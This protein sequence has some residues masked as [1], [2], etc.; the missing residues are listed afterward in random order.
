MFVAVNANHQTSLVPPWI[1]AAGQLW[2]YIFL[3]LKWSLSG[4]LS[5]AL[6]QNTFQ[7]LIV[8]LNFIFNC[9]VWN[10]ATNRPVIF[11]EG[12]AQYSFHGADVI[13]I[14]ALCSYNC[15]LGLIRN[16]KMCFSGMVEDTSRTRAVL[17][18]SSYVYDCD[19]LN[20]YRDFARFLPLTT[21]FTLP[22]NFQSMP[23]IF[24]CM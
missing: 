21:N 16:W 11:L 23:H 12:M 14:T 18:Y 19:S 9:L 1:P 15:L 5:F 13:L 4:A 17:F 22:T 6:Q 3:K 24:L 10:T 7:V 20:H 8:P 2:L